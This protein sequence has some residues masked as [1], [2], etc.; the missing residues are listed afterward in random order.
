MRLAIGMKNF[1][2]EAHSPKFCFFDQLFLFDRPGIC[3]PN[4]LP[5]LPGTL[6]IKKT[7]AFTAAIRFFPVFDDGAS[8]HNLFDDIVSVQRSIMVVVDIPVANPEVELVIGRITV[9]WMRNRGVAT[10]R[11]AVQR[12]HG[13]RCESKENEKRGRWTL[14]SHAASCVRV[15]DGRGGRMSPP[16]L[17]SC[18]RQS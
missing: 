5:L 2:L 9:T 1:S 17:S 14:K 6:V 8:S 7:F 4:L 16:R 13:E 3:Y 10:S 11:L 18:G 12:S 15:T